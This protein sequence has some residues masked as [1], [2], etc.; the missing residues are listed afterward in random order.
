VG[1]SATTPAN[2]RFWWRLRLAVVGDSTF[3][4][5]DEDALGGADV[6]QNWRNELV[7]SQ[8]PPVDSIDLT[9]ARMRGPNV[10]PRYQNSRWDPQAGRLVAQLTSAGEE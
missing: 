2:S 9:A 6:R 4:H 5:D 3:L 7:W 1:S 10:R 8:R